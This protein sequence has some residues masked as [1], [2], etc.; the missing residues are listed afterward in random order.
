MDELL[1]QDPTMVSWE[2]LPDTA[3]L[4]DKCFYLY[5]M[6]PF[7]NVDWLNLVRSDKLPIKKMEKS[8]EIY[9]KRNCTTSYLQIED[10]PLNLVLK[11]LTETC[12][13]S[14][15]ILNTFQDQQLI[16]GFLHNQDSNFER[17]KLYSLIQ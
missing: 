1:A 16:Q 5:T 13:E 3:S 2:I 8:P 6:P 9:V 11:R 7:W 10:L 14:M 15:I 17:I 4:Q 12:Q